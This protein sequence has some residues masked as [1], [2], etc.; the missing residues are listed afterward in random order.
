MKRLLYCCLT[1]LFSIVSAVTL[2]GFIYESQQ[3]HQEGYV[4]LFGLIC[5]GLAIFSLWKLTRNN[6]NP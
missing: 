1:I 6:T 3:D 5:G 4:L 2:R